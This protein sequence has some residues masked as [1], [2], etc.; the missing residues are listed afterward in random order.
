MPN[1]KNLV[2]LV[3]E[4]HPV[5]Q[6]VLGLLLESLGVRYDFA[7]DGQQAID[8]ATH[9]NYGL[10][11]MDCMMPHVDGFEAAFQIRRSEFARARH[12]PIIAVTAMDKDR[13]LDQC[14]RCGINDYIAKPIDRDILKEKITYWSMIPVTLEAL[15]PA[16]EAQIK[17][18]EV[19]QE[20]PIDRAY[21]NLLYGVQQLDDVLELFMTVTDNLMTELESAIEHHDVSIVRRMVHEIKGS[22]YT[23]SARE[24]AQVCRELE[25][26]SEEQ[27]W[28]EI[29]KLYV[30][31]GLA[32]ARVRECLQNKEKLLTEIKRTR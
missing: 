7:N 2:V 32:F 3:A 5:N 13:I 14:V 20:K 21:L 17:R 4:D 8:A 15:S 31:L 26:A 22:S 24:M 12:T 10:I 16:L 11:L 18:L 29:E 23:V 25:Q 6:K 19:A 30:A 1:R 27:D 9:F 28:P